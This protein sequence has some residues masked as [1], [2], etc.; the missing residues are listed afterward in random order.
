MSELIATHTDS[1]LKKGGAKLLK[2]KYEEI[3]P[4]IVELFTRLS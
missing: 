2:V 1:I 3:L 4:K